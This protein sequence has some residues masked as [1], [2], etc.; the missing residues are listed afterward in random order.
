LFSITTGNS[1]PSPYAT[2]TEVIAADACTPKHFSVAAIVTT[3]SSLSAASHESCDSA[4]TFM[5]YLP[6][7]TSFGLYF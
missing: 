4:F 7:S 5:V 3:I 6:A 2:S 1:A